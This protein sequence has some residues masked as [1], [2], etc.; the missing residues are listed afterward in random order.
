MESLLT[1]NKKR[2]SQENA[3]METIQ[4]YCEEESRRRSN[5]EQVGE[6]EPEEG[7]AKLWGQAWESKE[8]RIKSTSRFGHF[9][10]YRLRNVV[11]KGGD[12]LRQEIICMQL[13]YKIEQIIREAGLNI[14]VK[15]YEIIVL[16][17]NSGILE[18]VSNSM[19]VD[20][21]KKH[22]ED[23]SLTD[24]YSL[25]FG[26]GAAYDDALDCFV[27]SLA[28]S[29]ILTYVLKLKDRHNG[30][31]LLDR[32]GHIIQIDFGFILGLAPGKINFESSPFKLTQEYLDLMEGRDSPYFNQFVD[33]FCEGMAALR[34]RLEE[35]TLILEVMMEQSDLDCFK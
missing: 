15:P 21:M 14:V 33:L 28:G 11:V 5:S 35:L 1:A 6:G 10:S 8:R 32:E 16:S 24:F 7:P 22:T 17:E 12:D 30:N 31:I 18:F 4:E 19:S 25:A 29:A 9:K 13:V 27:R 26:P 20:Y 34:L 2:L 23:S 3:E